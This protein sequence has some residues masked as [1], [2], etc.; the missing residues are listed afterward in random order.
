MTDKK[1]TTFLN[2]IRATVRLWT[3]YNWQCFDGGVMDCLIRDPGSSTPHRWQIQQC[4]DAPGPLPPSYPLNTKAE[5]LMSGQSASL[6][7]YLS[8]SVAVLPSSLLCLLL[9]CHLH[10]DIYCLNVCLTV[11]AFKT[12]RYNSIQSWKII[13]FARNICK[14]C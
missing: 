11:F 9:S 8:V 14:M 1:A 2:G 10:W 6:P 5:S 4:T 3:E 13:T 12:T 7:L